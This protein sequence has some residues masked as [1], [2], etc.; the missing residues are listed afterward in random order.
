MKYKYII[1]LV[2]VGISLWCFGALNKILHYPNAALII[3]I[4]YAI[5]IIAGIVALLKIF[6][7]NKEDDV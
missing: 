2:F 5:F 3:K 1:A 6:I 4:S 7:F